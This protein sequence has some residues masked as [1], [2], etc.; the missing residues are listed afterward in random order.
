MKRNNL[1]V[2]GTPF[3]SWATMASNFGSSSIQDLFATSHRDFFGKTA[4]EFQAGLSLIQSPA[5]T[6]TKRMNHAFAPPVADMLKMDSFIGISPLACWTVDYWAEKL[7]HATLLAFYDSPELALTLALSHDPST[8]AADYLAVWLSAAQKLLAVLRRHRRRVFLFNAEECHS[9]SELFLQWVEKQFA[10]DG[11]TLESPP[12]VNPV[13]PSLAI[14]ARVFCEASPHVQTTLKELEAYSVPIHP[15]WR[16][17]HIAEL[18]AEVAIQEYLTNKEQLLNQQN[19]ID[20]LESRLNILQKKTEIQLQAAQNT[21]ETL[22]KEI[23]SAQLNAEEFF[24]QLVDADQIQNSLKNQV[25]LLHQQA[26]NQEATHQAELAQQIKQIE[27]LRHESSTE[28]ASAQAELEHAQHIIQ[29]SAKE[30]LG[31]HEMLLQEIRN[32]QLEAEEY[33]EKL[34][35]SEAT[36]ASLLSQIELLRHQSSAQAVATQAELEHAQQIIQKSAEETLGT[37]EMLL[38]EIRNTQLKA[39]EYHEKLEQSEATQAS[40]LSQIELLR[41][42][43]STQAASAQAELEHTQQII[44][45]S[46]EETLGSH[47]ML[48]QEIRNAQLEAEEYNKKLEQSEAAQASLSSQIEQLRHESSTQAA[49][50]QAE[51]E[52]AQQL[53]EQ[54]SQ[55]ARNTHEMLLL[56]IHKAFQKSEVHYER[57]KLAEATPLK[58]K[59]KTESLS[60]GPLHE[61]GQHRHWNFSLN[62]VQLFDQTWSQV[63]CRLIEHHGYAG[64]LIFAADNPSPP[65]LSVWAPNGEEAGR[66]FQLIV[67]DNTRSRQWLA[68]TTTRDFVFIHDCVS[69]VIADLTIHGL[70]AGSQTHWLRVAKRLQGEIAEIPQHLHHDHITIDTKLGESMGYMID[71]E[72]F[73]A[74]CRGGN[75][76]NL[77]FSWDTRAGH[78]QIRL[79][80]DGNDTPPLDRWP[81]NADGTEADEAIFDFIKGKSLKER[82]T[83]W[84]S[85]TSRDRTLLLLILR[86]IPNYVCGLDAPNSIIKPKIKSFLKQIRATE[87]DAKALANPRR[88]KIWSLKSKLILC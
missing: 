24:E 6:I 26:I 86:E 5:E 19:I 23:R 49:A 48:L 27:Q 33:H 76:Q 52:L 69:S 2:L 72:V 81:K 74:F 20:S 44:Q 17:C 18:G 43:S 32:A 84:E 64:L 82:R 3:G 36:Q 62:H 30:T 14:L 39:E 77:K 79:S 87:K 15:D 66:A 35:Q 9:H 38:Q 58:L 42:E 28:A 46:A 50:A 8:S 57:L 12:Q 88:R 59:L 31:T 60:R 70:P 75:L 22:R 40:L 55:E 63:D 13:N 51:L 1:L 16:R 41:H 85:L 68:T 61:E 29:K 10:I 21:Q 80:K 83:Q 4:S 47:E 67:L 34:E 56:E 45:K 11:V 37:H 7:P 53:F 78:P 73:H 25:D 65:I 71:F 54:A